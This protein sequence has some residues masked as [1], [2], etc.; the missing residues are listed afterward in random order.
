[1]AVTAEFFSFLFSSMTKSSP[2][3][4][5]IDVNSISTG[6]RGSRL[7]VDLSALV[8]ASTCSA[9]M[10]TTVQAK[11]RWGRLLTVEDRGCAVR[12]LLD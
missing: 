5:S 8:L 3:S 11:I 4:K 12:T 9:A 2:K 10:P 7:F 1:M 6:L